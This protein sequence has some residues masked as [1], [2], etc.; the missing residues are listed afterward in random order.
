MLYALPDHEVMESLL[1]DLRQPPIETALA[2]QRMSE[3]P[4]LVPIAIRPDDGG[5]VYFADIGD[6]PF[7]EW[8]YIYTVE[9]LIQSGR[10][11]RYFSTRLDILDGPAPVDDALAPSGLIF[12]VSRCGSTLFCKALA[13]LPSNLIINQGGPLQSGFWAA[14]TDGWTRPLEASVTNLN[15]LR[16]LIALMTRQRR[17]EYRHAFIKFISWN[18][19]YMDFI[20]AALPD[21]RALYLYRDPAEVISVVLEETT[22]ALKLRHTPL[23]PTLTGLPR[24]QI[25]ALDDVEFLAHCYACYFRTVAGQPSGAGLGLSNFCNTSQR[26]NF[27]DILRRGLGW[28]PDEERLAAM[29]AQY[30]FYS[31]DDSNQTVYAGEPED[32]RSRLGEERCQAIDAITNDAYRALERAENNL[33]P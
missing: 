27:P 15:R 5:L 17:P 24:E 23:A 16:N 12:H 2:R 29:Q 31:K 13:R 19:V 28:E 6:E 18:T 1:P 4:G 25:D 14:I 7:L 3:E 8:K 20:R 21:T 30:D 26:R 32:L 10:I 22:A 11:R 9:R 33:F